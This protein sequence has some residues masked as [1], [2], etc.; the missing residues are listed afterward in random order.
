MCV[1]YMVYY[2]KDCE[3]YGKELTVNEG[4]TIDDV[5]KEEIPSSLINGIVRL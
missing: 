2:T 1:K 5:I 4:Q 3:V